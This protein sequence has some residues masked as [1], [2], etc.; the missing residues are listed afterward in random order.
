MLSLRNR[1]AEHTKSYN[2]ALK[3]KKIYI[4]E[5]AYNLRNCLFDNV[6]LFGMQSAHIIHPRLMK[7]IHQTQ[8]WVVVDEL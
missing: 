3:C 7:H 6:S 4:Y 1:K 8:T 5:D 2:R